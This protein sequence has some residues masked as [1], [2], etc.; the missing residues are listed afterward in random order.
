M[1]GIAEFNSG[2]QGFR[3]YTTWF[4]DILY[5]SEGL[6]ETVSLPSQSRG[7]AVH[8]LPKYDLTDYSRYVVV[9][10][11]KTMKLVRENS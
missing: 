3:R 5:L 8:D 4:I 10:I 7:K 2:M 9:V 1:E 6:S 11:V